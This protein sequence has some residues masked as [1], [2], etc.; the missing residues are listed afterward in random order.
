MLNLR[1]YRII[2]ACLPVNEHTYAY[3]DAFSGMRVLYTSC[4]N[5]S[6]VKPFTFEAWV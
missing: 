3:L 6:Y 1:V 5:V 2:I 4:T